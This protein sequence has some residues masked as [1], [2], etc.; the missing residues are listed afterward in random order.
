MRQIPRL[1]RPNAEDTMVKTK[2][3]RDLSS[4]EI[5]HIW[6]T[7]GNHKNGKTAVFQADSAE[8]LVTRWPLALLDPKLDEPRQLFEWKRDEVLKE[9]KATNDFRYE[10]GNHL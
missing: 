1:C 10:P 7:D 3:D 4:S 5:R 2:L 9:L 8:V 6:F